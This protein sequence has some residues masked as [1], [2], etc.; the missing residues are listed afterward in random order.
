MT[1][2]NPRYTWDEMVLMWQL[3]AEYAVCRLGELA[4]DWAMPGPPKPRLTREQRI[5]ARVAEMELAAIEV[6]HRIAQDAATRAQQL[7]GTTP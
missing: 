1:T 6:R 3:G 4:D 5:A 2:D 7:K